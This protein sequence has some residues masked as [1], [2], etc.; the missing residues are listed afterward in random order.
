MAIGNSVGKQY[1]DYKFVADKLKLR[2]NSQTLV[3]GTDGEP[4]LERAKEDNFPIE[5]SQPNKTSIHLRCFY[6]V[7][8]DITRFL[9]TKKHIDFGH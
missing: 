1:E 6:H 2:S 8:D 4:A 9:Q 5:D 7:K 3:Y